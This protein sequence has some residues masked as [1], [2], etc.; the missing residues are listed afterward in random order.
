MPHLELVRD[1]EFLERKAQTVLGNPDKEFGDL[2]L[3]L[4]GFEWLYTIND[5]T[6]YGAFDYVGGE[7]IHQ[8]P[9]QEPSRGWKFSEGTLGFGLDFCTNSEVFLEYVERIIQRN[10]EITHLDDSYHGKK[11]RPNEFH[12]GILPMNGLSIDELP[13]Q[14]DLPSRDVAEAIRKR[15]DQVWNEWREMVLYFEHL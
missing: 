8:V 2:L 3:K 6:C 5:S 12:F 9:E 13:L 10:R 14:I 4:N 11:L 15:R 1:E 7:G